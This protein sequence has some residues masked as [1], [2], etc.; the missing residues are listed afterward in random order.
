MMMNFKYSW[1]VMTK[2]THISC[3]DCEHDSKVVLIT[4]DTIH[5]PLNRLADFMDR[6]GMDY[7]YIEVCG[8]K[9]YIMISRYV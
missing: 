2:A 1:Y 9:M 8:F 7:E 5:E 3:M 4:A 6:R